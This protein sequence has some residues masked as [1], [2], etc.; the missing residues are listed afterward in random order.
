MIRRPPR[1]TLFPYTTLFRPRA[2]PR[3]LDLPASPGRPGEAAGLRGDR[4]GHRH[5][6]GGRPG[7]AG[8]RPRDHGRRGSHLRPGPGG[9]R[10]PARA[11]RAGVGA[12]R[13]PGA[14]C[15]GGVPE[16]GDRAAPHRSLRRGLTLR[17]IRL[18]GVAKTYRTRTGDL[19][20]ALAETAL[21]VGENE[22]VTLVGPSGCRKST[23]RKL[24]AGLVSPT[25]GRILVRDQVLTEPFP[26]RASACR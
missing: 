11:E 21:T 8:A 24:V 5:R 17:V 26:S 14:L 15:G 19:V 4:R 7:R 13:A 22:F 10:S 18:D 6:A 23:L 20:H 3:R 25:R 9:R 1:S 16:C 12:G 2:A